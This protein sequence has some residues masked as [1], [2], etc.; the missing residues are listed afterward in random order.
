[1]QLSYNVSRHSERFIKNFIM[2]GEEY[3]VYEQSNTG[4]TPL[5]WYLY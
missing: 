1:M 3:K 4:H 5:I 2:N